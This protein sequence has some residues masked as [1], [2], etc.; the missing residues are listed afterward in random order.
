MRKDQDLIREI[1]TLQNFLLEQISAPAQR[2]LPQVI[3]DM[4]RRLEEISRE[5]RSIVSNVEQEFPA[6]ANF[7]NPK[8][9]T[10]DQA[11]NVLTDGEVLVSIVTTD[12]AT[13]VWAIPKQ[14]PIGFHS[15]PIGESV[16][17]NKVQKLRLA[18]DVGN[19]VLSRMPAFDIALANSLYSDLLKPLENVL[20]SARSL[21]VTTGGS[22][23]QL[24]LAVLVDQ[25]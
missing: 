12:N 20:G 4:R 18:L 24:P 6:Y 13:F 7:V 3:E 15:V 25:P 10:I 8:P 5:R 16:M 17:S 23:S 19:T 9:P 21:I 2:Q 22:L 14:G 11:R 1:E